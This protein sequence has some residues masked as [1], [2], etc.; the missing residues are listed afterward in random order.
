[1]ENKRLNL[2]VGDAGGDDQIHAILHQTDV[3]PPLS[4]RCIAVG[5]TFTST[6]GTVGSIPID[7]PPGG[8]VPSM[9]PPGGGDHGGWGGVL[10]LP[11]RPQA[12]E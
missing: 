8:M 6:S 3:V 11:R 1:M 4:T 10:G 5:W 12:V 2:R 9:R 7:W